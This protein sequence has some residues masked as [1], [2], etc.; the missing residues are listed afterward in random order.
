MEDQSGWLIARR[1]TED[2]LSLIRLKELQDTF[3]ALA[4]P[5]RFNIIWEFRGVTSANTPT[6]AEF[7]AL[8]SF[9]ERLVAAVEETG[10]GT[11]CI[12]F[13]EPG[14]RE[15]VIHACSADSFL[16]ALN[17]MPQEREP[18]PIEIRHEHDPGLELYTSHA[19]GL[20]GGR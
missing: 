12:V 3:D 7:E 5:E 13:T 6:P 11:L 18:Y 15:Y 10:Q 9:E 20:R 4:V 19:R 16:N 2:G 8:G 17:S 14:Y 1:E